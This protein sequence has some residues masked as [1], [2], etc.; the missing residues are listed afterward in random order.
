MSA[1][2][3]VQKLLFFYHV[4]AVKTHNNQ[5]HT[6]GRKQRKACRTCGVVVQSRLLPTHYSRRD[7]L[8]RSLESNQFRLTAQHGSVISND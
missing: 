1:T 3:V 8:W 4:D 5:I 2:A 6:K 7:T